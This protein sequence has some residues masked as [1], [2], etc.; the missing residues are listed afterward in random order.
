MTV[1]KEPVLRARVDEHT[2]AQFEAICQQF[3]ETTS[4]RMRRLVEDFV[5]A[6]ADTLGL[7]DVRIERPAGYDWGAW[8]VIAALRFPE[9]GQWNHA[10]V[11]F[12]FPELPQ[13]R[14]SPDPEYG[15][16]VLP[17]NGA[18]FIGGHFMDGVWR[19]HVYSNGIAEDQNPVKIDAVKDALKQT[20]E[21]TLKRYHGG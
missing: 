4:E 11:V 17:P 15:A 1:A 16:A 20:I 12:Q 19:G 18:P 14:F 2:K 6:H 10:P 21:S 13:R 5:R 8:R 7:V 3:G 9:Q